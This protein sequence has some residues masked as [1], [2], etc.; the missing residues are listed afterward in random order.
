MNLMMVAIELDVICPEY[1]GAELMIIQ[2]FITVDG[3][4][5]VFVGAGCPG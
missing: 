3:N 5:P 2:Y 4:G 1:H